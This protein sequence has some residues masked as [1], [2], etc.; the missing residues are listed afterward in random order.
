[1]IT[2][3]C[4]CWTSASLLRCFGTGWLTQPCFV[5]CFSL[6]FTVLL[7]VVRRVSVAVLWLLCMLLAMLFL[8]AVGSCSCLA[9][10]WLCSSACCLLCSCLLLALP[11]VS[12]VELCSSVCCWLCIFCLL[13]ALLFC[14]LLALLVLSVAFHLRSHRRFDVLLALLVLCVALLRSSRHRL[15]GC[16]SVSDPLQRHF[17]VVHSFLDASL[18]PPTPLI[19][20]AP[21]VIVG[22]R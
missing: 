20:I 17:V 15:F 21:F 5:P 1:M 13:L 8:P 10:C 16:G 3:P 22:S 19:S 18:A 6:Y 9:C 11:S 2:L 4:P 7:L 12:T 14:L